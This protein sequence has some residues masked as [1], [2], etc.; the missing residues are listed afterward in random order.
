[1]CADVASAHMTLP[2]KLTVEL[3]CTAEQYNS[4]ANMIW[5]VLQYNDGIANFKVWPDI[6]A[7]PTELE[8]HWQG[9]DNYT[10]WT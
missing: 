1:M 10:H 4:I 7:S 3:D 2:R 6:Q 9:L 8:D 5:H